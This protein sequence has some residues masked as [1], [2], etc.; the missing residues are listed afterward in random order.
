MS[1][2]TPLAVAA[3]V[4]CALYASAACAADP[5]AQK[6]RG[7]AK[8]HPCTREG[9]PA[10]ALCGRYRVWEERPSM[11][12]RKVPLEIVLLPATGPS[13]APDPLL[14]LAG[15]PGDAATGSAQGLAGLTEVRTRRDLLFIDQ[16][17]SRTSNP[18]M[19]SFGGTDADLQTY[20]GEQF[21]LA[22]V[23]RCRE[24]LEPRANLRLYTTAIA[25]DDFAEVI[26]WLGYEQVNLFGGSYGTRAAQVFIRRHPEL[27]RSAI[28][29]G[30]TPVDETL[31]ISHAQGA[32]RAL[33]L[34][35]AACAAEPACGKAFPH[36]PAEF[37]AVRERLVKEPATADVTHPETGQ[38]AT[39]RLSGPDFAEAV[40]WL[41]YDVESARLVPLVV[42]ESFQGD[43]RRIADLAVRNRRGI[44]RQLALGM[45]LSVTCAEDLP[46]LDPA[47][48][49][50][51]TRGSFLGDDRVRQ[52][53]RACGEW[54]HG[55]VP[56]DHMALVRTDKPVLMLVGEM[57]P[58]T[59]PDFAMRV[60]AGLTQGLLVTIPGGA[61]SNFEPCLTRLMHDFLERGSARG[62]DTSCAAKIQHPPFLTAPT[63]PALR[64]NACSGRRPLG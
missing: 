46:F 49:P 38:P 15:G 25:V 35:F 12:G 30:V 45:M 62:V 32:Q 54:P 41:M 64:S 56:P 29:L 55:E 59:P 14:F 36:L 53:L 42:H 18:L 8:L 37:Q 50:E 5:P 19:C 11:T 34:V 28:L 27:V 60:A 1:R 17:G 3:L 63:Q 6:R 16:R 44:V 20:L 4:V 10:D 52:Q 48:V 39:V 9:L 21:P 33:D 58:V 13:P 24:Q 7:A 47:T 31:P 22:E 26:A 40:R 57:D 51:R 2:S 43:F 61:H 23:R